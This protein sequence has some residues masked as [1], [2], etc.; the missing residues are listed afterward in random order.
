LKVLVVGG[1]GREHTL[2]WKISRSPLVSKIYCAPG[3]TG[4]AR[5]AECVPL[6][7]GDIAG[8]A[9]F[10]QAKGVDLTVVGPELS[11]TLGIADEFEQ[12]GLAVFGVNKQAAQLEGSKVFMKNLLQKY[13]IPSA[14]Y[15]VFE[16]AQA[17]KDYVAQKDGPLVVKADGL[18]AGK[19]VLI[20]P[21]QAAAL[22]AVA[23]VME[24][25]AFG[26]AGARV[27]IEEYLEG[28]ELS[29]LAFTDGKTV[30]PMVSAQDHKA[31]YDGDKGPNTGGMGA[32]SPAPLVDERLYER[33]MQGVMLPTVEALAAEGCNYRGVLYAGLMIVEGKPYVLEFNARFGDPETQVILPR[34]ESDLIPVFL[35]V[36]RGE[37]AGME[38]NWKQEAAVC[39]VLASGGYPGAYQKGKLIK[40]LDKLADEDNLLV[41]HAGTASQEDG[42]VTAG[43]RVLGV[44][45]LAGELP[46]AISLAY[47][48]VRQLHFE[49]MYYRRDIGRK[50][51]RAPLIS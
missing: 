10:A 35:A 18:A 26:E 9:D 3:N 36:S 20:C 50:A 11:L 37:L 31:V 23:E 49:G 47:E 40:G 17:A 32:Y 29:F 51:F 25:R 2:V 34:L 33:I 46:E 4:I 19:G 8:L 44:T 43:G 22:E 48:G 24:R 16:D 15:R 6:A 42:V 45:A 1:G 21:D 41:F 27:V 14:E 38:L 30:L 12:R 7:A 39:V 28:E 5:L 13:N